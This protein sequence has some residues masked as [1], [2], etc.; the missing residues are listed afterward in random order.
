[1]KFEDDIEVVLEQDV[2]NEEQL[3]QFCKELQ[4]ILASDRVFGQLLLKS[5]SDIPFLDSDVADEDAQMTLL[6]AAE[7]LT[8]VLH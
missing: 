8:G 7:N 6:L 4:E 3:E 5:I 1:M 2:I